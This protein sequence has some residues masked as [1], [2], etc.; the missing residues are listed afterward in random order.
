[1]QMD[2]VVLSS[3]STSVD[4]TSQLLLEGKEQGWLKAKTLADFIPFQSKLKIFLF[5]LFG[6]RIPSRRE[7]WLGGGSI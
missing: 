7:R 2:F 3:C 6:L 1:M 5:F 4:E